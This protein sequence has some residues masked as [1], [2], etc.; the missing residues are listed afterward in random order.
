MDALDISLAVP[1]PW[2]REVWQRL[3]RL[4]DA[5]QLPH[6]LLLAGPEGVGKRRFAMALGA[7]LL[8]QALSNG[9]AC[10]R[11]RGCLLMAAGTHPDWSWL[12]PEERGK[13]IK[14]DQVRD[15]VESMAQTAQQGGRKLAV[16]A[17][18]EAMNRNAA[19]ALLKT[20]EEPSGRALL[21][22]ISD[23][24]ARLLPTIRSRCQRLDFPV[25]A[26]N[27]ASA[28]LA[29]L[30]GDPARMALAMAEAG[31]RPLLARQL[32]ESDGL[33]QRQEMTRT[34][35]AVL[36]GKLSLLAAAEAWQGQD[37]DALL[38]WLQARLAMA[39]R[40]QTAGAAAIDTAV[41]ALAAIVAPDLFAFIDR[42]REVQRHSRAGGNPNRQLV[43]EAVLIDL[44][45]AVNGKSAT[46]K[47]GGKP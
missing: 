1:L 4:R 33:E 21:L 28:W 16:L 2:Q 15:L 18:A 43:L 32:L 7:S 27:E 34:L 31:D 24:P 40:V 14:I 11:C 17:P 42:L 5:D 19:N 20:L 9:L 35:T 37:W 47:L 22:L 10:G 30:A 29:P 23:S 8:C 13:A 44:C 12:A 36:D 38:D 25:P 45:D 39:V 41:T 6:A 26:A 46:F 3:Q